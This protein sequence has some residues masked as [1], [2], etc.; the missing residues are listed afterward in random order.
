TRL[1]RRLVEELSRTTS[2]AQ[3]V[4]MG[5][6]KD[7]AF[8][9]FL[10]WLDKLIGL[11]REEAAAVGYGDGVPY[12]ALLDEYEPGARSTEIAAVFRPLREELVQLVAAIQASGRRPRVDVLER[13]Y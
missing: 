6:R 9:A 3:Q 11:K 5:A 8:S 2:L 7:K 10:P 4:W 13:E 12:D 1:P